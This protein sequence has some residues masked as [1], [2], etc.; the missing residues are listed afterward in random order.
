MRRRYEHVI[1][2]FLGIVVA[3]V[4]TAMLAFVV[5]PSDGTVG[6][7]S[8]PEV[9]ADE[10]SGEFELSMTV[11]DLIDPTAGATDSLAPSSMSSPTV[12]PPRITP[13]PTEPLPTPTPR[14]IRKAAATAMPSATTTPVPAPKNV[15]GNGGFNDGLAGW[16]VE[17]DIA[18]VDGIGRR[19][20]SAIRIGVLGGY[21]DLVIPVEP[22]QTYRL[23][24]WGNVS[25][26]GHAGLVGIGYRDADGNRLMADEP[27]ALAFDETTSVRQLVRFTPP[28]NA[29][30]VSVYLWNEPGSAAL[31]VDDISVREIVATDSST[32]AAS[33]S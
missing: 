26:P 23:A 21:A 7:F 5:L 18:V 19:G 14:G 17:G 3:S 12:E 24:A 11:N 9:G 33:M 2:V 4:V 10:A 8:P 15:V 25:V 31:I 1:S 16:Y 6:G 29:A 13:T 22:G 20:G 28:A 27:S 32:P 30:T